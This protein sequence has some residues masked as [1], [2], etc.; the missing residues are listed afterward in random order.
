MFS[1]ERQDSGDFQTE[2]FWAGQRNKK[3]V[4]TSFAPIADP[5]KANC[6][7]FILSHRET[8]DMTLQLREEIDINDL[9]GGLIIQ[10]TG[11]IK[12]KCAR[13]KFI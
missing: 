13:Q 6:G 12:S 9:H 10:N 5:Q 7:S 2:C 1:A 8:V 3:R 4:I 11:V